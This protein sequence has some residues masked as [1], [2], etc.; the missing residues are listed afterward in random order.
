MSSLAFTPVRPS[1][2]RNQVLD[3]LRGA[4]FQGKLQP[5]DPIREAR[6][7]AELSVSQNTVREALLELQ[8]LGLVVRNPNR[9]TLVTKLSDQDIQERVSVRLLLE[10]TCIQL[11]ARQMTPHHFKA[12]RELVREMEQAN[13]TEAAELDLKFHRTIWALSGHRVLIEI[14]EQLV[15]PLFAFVTIVRFRHIDKLTEL[16]RRHKVLLRALETRDESKIADAFRRH[17][18][19]HYQE[20]FKESSTQGE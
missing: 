17:L 7:A 1:S 15:L 11:A 5:G 14:L 13:G 18:T 2:V 10:P 9:N 16:A 12:L 4:I 6:I 3:V 8:K 19:D 20:F